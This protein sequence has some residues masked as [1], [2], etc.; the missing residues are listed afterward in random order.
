[1]VSYF[2][3]NNAKELQAVCFNTSK[4]LYIIQSSNIQRK[5]NILLKVN[6]KICLIELFI[7]NLHYETIWSRH[8]GV[9]F[10]QSAVDGA[11]THYKKAAVD[12]TSYTALAS[13]VLRLTAFELG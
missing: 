2:P 9:K 10:I 11:V 12:L 13:L 8:C 6:S 4:S 7:N 3:T 5:N 1:M